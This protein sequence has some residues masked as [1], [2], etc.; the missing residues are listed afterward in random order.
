[1][2]AQ[3]WYGIV[4]AVLGGLCV[5]MSA[6]FAQEWPANAAA[7]QWVGHLGAFFMA[8][9]GILWMASRHFT[10]IGPHISMESIERRIEE[11]EA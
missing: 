11:L 10:V 5:G 9:G 2:R 4:T 7:M 6:A 1:M 8:F 3:S